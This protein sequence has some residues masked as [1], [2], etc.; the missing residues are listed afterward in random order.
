MKKWQKSLPTA[1]LAAL[2]AF[3]SVTALADENEELEAE[4]ED[5]RQQAASQQE[6]TERINA[7]IGTISE[8]LRMI[9]AEVDEA[10]AEYNE[11][12]AVLDKLDAD[13]WENQEQLEKTEAELTEKTRLL[14]KRVR[15]IYM[16]GQ[17]NYVDVLFG[18]KD[19]S[20]FLTRMDLL[21][22][23]L[24]ND[25]DLVNRVAEVKR[26]VEA[27]RKVLDSE[28][29]E[30]AVVVAKAEEKEMKLRLRKQEKDRLLDKMEN[31]RD[32]SQRAYEELMAASK[33]V[34][35]LIQQNRYEAQRRAE[36]EA[37]ASAR[38]SYGG[39]GASSPSQGSGAMIWPVH[40]EI[41][42]PFGWRVHPIT[43][44]S[45][46]HSGMD[47]G[48]DYGDPIVAAASGTVIYSGWIS[49]YGYAVII[50]HGGG[51][52]T[53]Y[54]HNQSLAVGEGEAVSQGQVIAYCGSTGNSTGPHCHFEVRENGEP[55]E[56]LGYL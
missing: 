50:D 32:T 10:E 27:R 53:L 1:I 47:I 35:K 8:Q 29:A 54:G 5:L 55:V 24:R 17:V 40:G 37:R 13:I 33:E 6:E 4:L 34:E 41:T 56:P 11:V 51:I 30:Q 39:G 22:R 38:S 28:R 14:E 25:R 21:K 12:K 9:S 49:G 46:F 2:L 19:F 7:K 20:D 26:A 16:H 45:R 43:G 3:P 36:E 42:S 44:N 15:D 52:S 31:D 23:I 18:A 48:A